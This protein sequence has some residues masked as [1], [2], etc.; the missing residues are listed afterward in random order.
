MRTEATNTNGYEVIYDYFCT[1]QMLSLVYINVSLA[2]EKYSMEYVVGCSF[3][4]RYAVLYW[5]LIVSQ[6]TMMY[7]AVLSSKRNSM[8]KSYEY[9]KMV[10]NGKQ[11]PQIWFQ[12]NC[13][14]M[15]NFNRGHYILPPTGTHFA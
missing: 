14:Q 7:I 15:R 13:S 8:N 4:K 12:D 5:S 11:L 2:G 3:C 1:I 6:E 9:V 10:L